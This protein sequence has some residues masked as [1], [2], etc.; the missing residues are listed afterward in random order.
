M[1]YIIMNKDQKIINLTQLRIGVLVLL[2]GSLVYLFDRS[3]S[4]LPF[5]PNYFSALP[6]LPPNLSEFGLVFPA[7][8]HTLGFALITTA[9]LVLQRMAACVAVL[10]WPL[11]NIAFEL[12]QHPMVAPWIVQPLSLQAEDNI[13]IDTLR[14]FF[15]GGTFDVYDM[16]AIMIA[17]SSGLVI[18]WLTSEGG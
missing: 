5:L 9:I 16:A 2:L 4:G 12:G 8:A 3:A 1:S 10:L 15:Q 18:V 17:A 14:C 6:A 11:I 13:F 7:F